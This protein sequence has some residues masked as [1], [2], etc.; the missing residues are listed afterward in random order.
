MAFLLDQTQF[1]SY[2]FSLECEINWAPRSYGCLG[3]ECG[4]GAVLQ[5]RALE[6]S[7]N[8]QNLPHICCDVPKMKG[9]VQVCFPGPVIHI[10]LKLV[11]SFSFTYFAYP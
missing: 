8:S 10:E 6:D 11:S 5:V 3:F 9:S 2:F 1:F 4:A 7:I